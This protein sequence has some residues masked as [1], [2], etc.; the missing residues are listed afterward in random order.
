VLVNDLS[1][2]A[3]HNVWR[4]VTILQN[5][6][7]SAE[8]GWYSDTDQ[9]RLAHPY[10]TWVNNG[11][12]HTDTDPSNI[13]PL[14]DLHWFKVHDQNRDR[15]W[16]FAWEGNALGNEHVAMSS[17]TPVDQAERCNN[18]DTLWSHFTE[19]QSLAC[20]SCGWDPYNDVKKWVDNTADYRFCRIDSDTF[21]VK[22]V[23]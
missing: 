13:L 10:K 20:E 19:L 16:S 21:R 23:C 12:P 18:S 11:I 3:N 22:Q 4:S 7:Y 9:N 1:Q 8:V 14:D 17:A 2:D 15:D 5:G 6:N